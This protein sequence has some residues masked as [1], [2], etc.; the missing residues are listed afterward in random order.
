MSVFSKGEIDKAKALAFQYD[1]SM[2]EAFDLVLKVQYQTSLM[3]I[4]ECIHY[5]NENINDI[6]ADIDKITKNMEFNDD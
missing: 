4:N 3:D 6:S 1:M 5:I 2:Y